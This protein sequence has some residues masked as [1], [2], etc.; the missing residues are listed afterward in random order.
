MK[1]IRKTVFSESVQQSNA[2][3]ARMIPLS[4]QLHF[5]VDTAD[6]MRFRRPLNALPKEPAAVQK[7]KDSRGKKSLL[8]KRTSSAAQASQE[9]TMDDLQRTLR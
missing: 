9:S 3:I 5:E 4:H 2:M 6:F 1:Q 7:G 8:A